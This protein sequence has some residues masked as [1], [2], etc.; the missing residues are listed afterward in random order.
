MLRVVIY[1][2]NAKRR[3]GLRLLLDGSGTLECVGA[4]PDC[5]HVVREVAECA[6]D[7][8]LMDIDMPYVDGIQGVALLRKQFPELKILMQTVFED[9][10]K[11][12]DAPGRCGRL[13]VE[14]DRTDQAV[15]SRTGSAC[16]WCTHVTL[17]GQKVLQLFAKGGRRTEQKEEYSLTGR[18]Q[19]ILTLL[20]EGYSYKM[21]AEACHV[22]TATVNSHVSHIYAKLHVSSAAGAVG[23]ALRE[24]LV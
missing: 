21:I 13:P 6:P 11:I 4:F 23:V 12:F 8:V 1:D 10:D 24:G 15:G 19:E 9:N 2:D 22:T 14:T 3:E 17:R 7:V 20:V 18:E 5:R 16:R